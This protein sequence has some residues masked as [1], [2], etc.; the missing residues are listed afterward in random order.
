[1]TAFEILLLQNS[2]ALVQKQVIIY[3]VVWIKK[4]NVIEMFGKQM[5]GVSISENGA[6]YSFT[7]L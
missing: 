5:F 2:T 1:M 6:A 7:W 3:E 4:K